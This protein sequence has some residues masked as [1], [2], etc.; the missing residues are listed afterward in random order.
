MSAAQVED[1]HVQHGD[2]LHQRGAQQRSSRA[3]GNAHPGAQVRQGKGDEHLAH[4]LNQLGGGGGHHVLLPLHETAEGRQHAYDGHAGGDHQKADLA[5]G[6]ID[7]LGQHAAARQNHDGAQAAQARQQP[8]RHPEHTL[9]VAGIVLGQAVADHAGDGHGQ[10]CGGDG[11]QQVVGGEDGLIN[12]QAV[13]TDEPGQRN[14]EQHA[15]QLADNAGEAQ[16]RHAAHNRLRLCHKQFLSSFNPGS[17]LLH[18]TLI[19]RRKR[20]RY[21]GI[22]PQRKRVHQIITC[23]FPAAMV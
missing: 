2:G 14:D 9:G 6:L 7:A 15:H 19:I 23:I 10:A 18:I 13:R 5:L 11:Q 22:L 21:K 16:H 8:Q 1:D 20:A 12:A 17:I 4:L 3:L